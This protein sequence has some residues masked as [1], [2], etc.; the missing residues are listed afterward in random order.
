MKHNI[1]LILL[2]FYSLQVSAQQ[3]TNIRAQ[4]EGREIAIYYD[5]SEQAN[6]RAKVYIDGKKQKMQLVSGDI[7]K[8]IAEGNKHRIAWQVLDERKV[9]V[10][11]A[12]NVVFKV[13]ANAPY[14]TFILAEGGLS[15]QPLQPSGGLMIG[16]VSRVGWYIKA[17]SSFQFTHAD[18]MITAE[19]IHL[20]DETD[21]NQADTDLLPYFLTGDTKRKQWVADAGVTVRFWHQQPHSFY[22]LAGAGY[23]ERSRLWKG[24]DNKWYEDAVTA[25]KGVSADLNLMYT[26]KHLAVSAG[27]NTI[28]FKYAEAQI[29][30]GVIF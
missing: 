24:K 7:G 27:I 8:N 12:R 13:T 5:L 4:A 30:L 3:V 14:R 26:Y 10:F 9:D 25:Y 28:A 11:Q 6:V 16:G 21:A 29:G 22:L 2:L 23:G 17:R 15:P 20:A 1:I 18:G 19:G